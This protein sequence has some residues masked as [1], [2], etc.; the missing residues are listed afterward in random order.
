MRGGQDGAMWPSA[1]I[2]TTAVKSTMLRE[3]EKLHQ[4]NVRLRSHQESSYCGD[5]LSQID[6]SVEMRQ[7]EKQTAEDAVAL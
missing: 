6:Y 2:R 4:L 3:S 7:D 1:G 5:Q